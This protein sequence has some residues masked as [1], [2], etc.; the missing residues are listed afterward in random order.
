MKRMLKIGSYI[1]EKEYFEAIADQGRIRIT[2][3]NDDII[4]TRV[5]FRSRWAK[6][7]S[8]VLML[9]AWQ[10]ETDA[11]FQGER[12]RVQACEFELE[13]T[14]S[15][16]RLIGRKLT[17]VL[18]KDPFQMEIRNSEG[19][20]LCSDIA[21]RSYE[22]DKGRIRHYLAMEKEDGFYGFGEK[23]G[24]LNKRF[25]R[26]KM[27]C[28]DT[29]GYDGEYSDPLYKHIPF[30]IRFDSYR[31]WASG[32][33]YHILSP[34]EW[35]VGA[36][37]SAYWPRFSCFQAESEECDWYFI[38]GPKFSDVLKNYTDLTGKSVLLP[39][40]AYGYLGSAM[41]YTEQKERSDQAIL[42]FVSKAEEHRI[43]CAGF[44]LSSGYTG[45]TDGKR[46]VFCW[47]KKRF[48]YPEK[49]ISQ[50][51]AK[52][53]NICP[54][55]KPGMLLTHPLYHEFT[56]KGAYILDCNRQEPYACRYWGGN[57]SFVDFTNPKA[58]QLWTEYLKKELLQKGITGIW[59][60]NNEYELNEP[61]AWCSYE[62]EGARFKDLRAIMP[63]MMAYTAYH[64]IKEMG[65][66]PFLL[67]RAGFAGIQRYAQTWSGDN[68]TN[69]KS[70]RY[71]ISIALGM[72]LS[73]VSNQGSD[74]GG[75]DGPMPEAELF[76]RWVQAGVLFPRFSIHSCNTDNTVT[77][78]WSYASITEAVGNVIRLRQSLKP[79]L[80]SLAYHSWQSGEPMMRPLV[81]EYQEDEQT[82][83]E[84]FHYLCGGFLL[85]APVLEKG[86]K[87]KDIYLPKG[88]EWTDW[89]SGYRYQGGQTVTLPVE[90]ES[91]PMFIRSGSIIPS[92]L[93]NKEKENIL[94]IIADPW[95][96]TEFEI[97]QDDEVSLKYQDGDYYL[98]QIS[99]RP[100]PNKVEIEVKERGKIGE[101]PYPKIEWEILCRGKAPQEIIVGQNKLSRVLDASRWQREGGFYFDMERN[102]TLIAYRTEQRD[103][104]IVMNFRSKDLI[105]I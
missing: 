73:G 39:A 80:Y 40:Y 14:E 102:R 83:E 6:D 67:N 89:N 13:E 55:I 65:I 19:Q 72:S 33:F 28:C 87:A 71:S 29:L 24:R 100:E 48:P 59:N 66:R 94:R 54:N 78:P 64:A 56:E 68:E 35:D 81:Y 60:D 47:N 7:K 62:G 15:S 9:T 98:T 42:E 25:R 22:Q 90:Q 11:L 77:E 88:R 38:N 36:L 23:S 12:K 69:W 74:I 52:G 16:Y 99:C 84:S 86:A 91:L 61:D 46:Y 20:L 32:I 79:Y 27:D 31:K 8:Y 53:V 44:H 58:R 26:F 76:L 37:R 93:K 45:G 17:I 10:D 95:Q 18:K 43:P 70:L 104:K 57:A 34:A 92:M 82:W 85:V 51:Q 63:N 103:Y 5:C 101:N 75:F 30:A 97:F 96:E 41:Y 105:S 3:L 21:G 4:R 1:K 2:F 50:M 49:W